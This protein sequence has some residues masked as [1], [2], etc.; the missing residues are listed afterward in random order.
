MAGMPQQVI[1]ES[2]HSLGWQL[3][4]ICYK[5]RDQGC[6]EQSLYCKRRALLILR[7]CLLDGFSNSQDLRVEN[8]ACNATN[9]L[10]QF[11]NTKATL[12]FPPAL[13]VPAVSKLIPD[14]SCSS[15]PISILQGKRCTQEVMFGNT[16]S[17]CWST[18]EPPAGHQAP[19]LMEWQGNHCQAFPPQ[20]YMTSSFFRGSVLTK[21]L[22]ELSRTKVPG[23]AFGQLPPH[24]FSAVAFTIIFLPLYSSK[25]IGP[26]AVFSIVPRVPKSPMRNRFQDH[27]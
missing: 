22:T 3:G 10:L 19:T 24:S 11:M 6:N 27:S 2:S 12:A 1:T 26:F 20:K 13:A 18:S 17:I 16:T 14:Y 5:Q 21:M 23:S 9:I 4:S 15:G 7:L 25:I 8:H